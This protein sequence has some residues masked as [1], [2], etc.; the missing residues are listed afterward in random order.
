MTQFDNNSSAG[1]ERD[2]AQDHAF[3]G[4]GMS[5]TTRRNREDARRKAMTATALALG[6]A[7]ALGA[8]AEAQTAPQGYQVAGSVDHVTNVHLNA[9]GS[10]ELTL[11]NGNV[12]TFAADDVLVQDGVVYISESAINAASLTTTGAGAA[13]AGGGGGAA[14]GALAGLGLVGAAAGGGGGGG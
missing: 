5:D 3:E 6:G 9:D 2:A 4:E 1:T 10:V 11:N 13:A 12:V 8:G 14:I 7:A